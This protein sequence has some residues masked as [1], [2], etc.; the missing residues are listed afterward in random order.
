MSG[1]EPAFGA[2][3]LPPWRA[4]LRGVMLG[5][6]GGRLGKNL[7]SVLRRIMLLGWSG[8]VDI[9]DFR[10]ARMRL[11]HAD[12]GADRYILAW[13]AGYDRPELDVICEALDRA[14][15]RGRSAS[16]VDLGANSGAYALFAASLA[17]RRG[18]PIRVLA[19]EPDPVNRER[20]AVN[21]AANDPDLAICVESRAASGR[22]ERVRMIDNPGNRGGVTTQ[23]AAAHEAGTVAAL[24]LADLLAEHDLVPDILKSDIEG[25]DLPV[26]SAYLQAVP[27]PQR[28][29]LL[30]A[31][32]FPEHSVELAAL[33][34]SHGYRIEAHTRENIIAW[35]LVN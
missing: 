35:R 33:L 10:G 28:P 16:F 6:P 26:L 18:Q 21:L 12:N 5:L 25:R 24:P 34:E 20:L 13:G 32:A 4:R 9:D 8:P 3:R 14:W 15:S 7:R 22:H 19:I 31:E 2:F 23:P 11:H 27:A 1:A 17:V 29:H 30:I